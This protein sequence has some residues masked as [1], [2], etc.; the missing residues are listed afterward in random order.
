MDSTTLEMDLGGLDI[1]TVRPDS[2]G[3]L[4]VKPE[5]DVLCLNRG[6]MPISDK[7]DSKDHTIPVGYFTIAYGAARHFKARAVVPGSRNPETRFQASFLA[8]LGVPNPDGK[9]V[10]RFVGCD[11]LDQCTPFTEEECREYGHAVEAIDRAALVD[12]IDHDVTIRTIAG[13]AGAGGSR[14]KG[15]T[16][17]TGRRSTAL[18][19]SAVDV[20]QTK[21]R[22]ETAGE[23]RARE[24][25]RD[26]LGADA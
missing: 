20:L 24:Q 8:I 7:F 4:N 19:G 13:N 3:Q 26:D 23:R 14:V 18:S 1:A 25:S 15:G 5:T 6:R 11:D 2:S 21:N 22:A 17:P 16:I 10:R 9:G 12:P